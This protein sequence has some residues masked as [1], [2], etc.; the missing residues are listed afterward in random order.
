[1][2][3]HGEVRPFR[4]RLRDG[5]STAK[6]SMRV[7]RGVLLILRDD[8]GRRGFGEAN[9]IPGFGREDAEISEAVLTDLVPRLRGRRIEDR[10][11]LLDLAEEL[12]SF[13]PAARFALDT[14]LADL[15]AQRAGCSLADWL[16]GGRAPRHLVPV[17]A[18]VSGDDPSAAIAEGFRVFKLKVGAHALA[19]DL[20]RVEGLRLAVGLRAR[21]RLDANAAWSFDEARAAWTRWP[22]STSSTWKSRSRFWGALGSSFSPG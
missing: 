17:N 6:G 10:D 18:L 7:R 12:A 8:V 4:L 15:S 20:V 11:D 9:P 21:I 13:A 1:M 22:P 19:R 5:L 16:A 14:A 3:V 2:I